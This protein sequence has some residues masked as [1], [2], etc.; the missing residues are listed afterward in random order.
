MTNVNKKKP[1]FNIVEP[2]DFAPEGT[3]ILLRP[4]VGKVRSMG[5]IRPAKGPFKKYVLNFWTF[6]DP[7]LPLRVI[8][9]YFPI[10]LLVKYVDVAW[11][12]IGSKQVYRA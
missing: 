10:L 12:A 1:M 3:I 9:C 4:G 11:R 5:Q 6:L 7:S 2:K 8:L